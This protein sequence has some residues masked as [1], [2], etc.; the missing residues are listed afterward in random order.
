[1]RLREQDYIDSGGFYIEPPTE[2]VNPF[3]QEQTYLPGEWLESLR[4][5]L[6]RVEARRE[7]L[8]GEIA[9]EEARNLL[10]DVA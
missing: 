2:P 8:I 6:A 4:E 9:D 5:E 7:Y 3:A 1:M 10:T